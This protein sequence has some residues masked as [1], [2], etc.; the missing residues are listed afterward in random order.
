MPS[1]DIRL[2]FLRVRS[3]A[4]FDTDKGE[5]DTDE[6]EKYKISFLKLKKMILYQD[7]R[8]S[9]ISVENVY[10]ETE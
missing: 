6:F 2:D 4:N 10:F 1:K 8:A 5:E 3:I 9:E 7:N